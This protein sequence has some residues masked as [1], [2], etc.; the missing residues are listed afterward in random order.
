MT[1]VRLPRGVVPLN[2]DDGDKEFTG[3]GEERE[4]EGD[5]GYGGEKGVTRRRWKNHVG[6]G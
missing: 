2:D 4:R 1:R 5:Y 6:G 3:G